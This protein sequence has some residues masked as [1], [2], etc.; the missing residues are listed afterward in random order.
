VE[1]SAEVWNLLADGQCS[2]AA[3]D[4]LSATD[5]GKLVPAEG[6]AGSEVS[7][8]ELRECRERAG[9][10]EE[11]GGEGAGCRGGTI[12]VPTHAFFHGICRWRVGGGTRFP[13][14]FLWF[15]LFSFFGAHYI[16]SGQ[17]RGQKGSLQ[18]AVPCGQRTGN[19]DKKCV[20]IVWIG[21]VRV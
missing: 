14:L 16:F 19:L 17:G 13:L 20:T 4:F 1:E 15:G 18:R 8:W 12:A 6:D 9:G 7:E 11:G 10:R 3:L 2:Q 21:C 5:V